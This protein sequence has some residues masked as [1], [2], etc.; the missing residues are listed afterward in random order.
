MATNT[1]NHLG[2]EFGQHFYA[3]AFE[4]SSEAKLIAQEMEKQGLNA[5]PDRSHLF[6]LFS[7]DSLKSLAVSIT[8]YSSKDLSHEGGLSLSEG[9]HAQGVIVEMKQHE[10]VAF[11]HLAVT[12]GKLVSSKHTVAELRGQAGPSAVQVTEAHIKAFAEKIGKVKT[13]KPLVEV[14]TRQVRS[15]ASISY[16][17]LLGDSFSHTVHSNADIQQLR[18]SADVVAQIALFVL[19]RTEGSACCS[20]SCSCWGSS[21]CSSSYS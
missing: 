9:G 21:S 13:A 15:L 19:F 6:T 14:D 1:V 12:G 3:K 8:P 2:V 20:C 16:S 11:T 18:G 17:A 7:Q 10:I 5:Q 4:A